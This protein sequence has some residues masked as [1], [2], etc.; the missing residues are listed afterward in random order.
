M[1]IALSQLVATVQ[2]HDYREVVMVDKPVPLDQG[3]T[4]RPKIFAG[5]RLISDVSEVPGRL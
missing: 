1:V 5:W 3:P 2:S 4:Q